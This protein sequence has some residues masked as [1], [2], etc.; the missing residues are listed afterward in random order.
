MRTPQESREDLQRRFEERIKAA[1]VPDLVP[2]RYR[3]LASVTAGDTPF[4]GPMETFRR[5]VEPQKKAS[6]VVEFSSN[7]V[8]ARRFS[9]PAQFAMVA[10]LFGGMFG[11]LGLIMSLL[12]RDFADS[13]PSGTMKFIALL[14]VVMVIPLGTAAGVLVGLNILRLWPQGSGTELHVASVD[15]GSFINSIDFASTQGPVTVRIVTRRNRLEKALRLAQQMP[16][17]NHVFRS[18]P[19]A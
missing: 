3:F 16:S 4:L 2:D 7:R 12:P 11:G 18:G 15:F 5:R 19:F 17:D 6:F 9:I 8:M 13:I 14:A 10:S 1:S